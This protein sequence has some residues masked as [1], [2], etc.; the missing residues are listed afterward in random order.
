MKT[1]FPPVA[2]E[3]RK[4]WLVDADGQALG[5]LATS[6]ARLLMGKHKPTYTTFL[7]HG[8]HVIV[9][10]AGKV[11]LTGQKLATKV[12]RHHTGYPG[13]VVERRAAAVK[14]T[15]PDRMLREAIE[16]MLP[17]SKLGRAM[18][19]KLRV[20]RDATHP[21]RGQKPQPAPAR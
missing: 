1:Y 16:G 3:G 2:D 9:I 7:D 14:S 4:W 21:H 5:R 8:D 6:V 17:K 12:Y 10:N 18:A 15:R 13:G 20:Y 19:R 11:H